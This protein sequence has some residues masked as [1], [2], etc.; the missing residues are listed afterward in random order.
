MGTSRETTAS[1]LEASRLLPV[2]DHDDLT[3]AQ[4]K[5]TACVWC[6]TPISTDTAVDLGQ[7][8]AQ[9]R[10]GHITVSPRACRPCTAERIP[11]ALGQHTATCE[12]CV[13]IPFGCDT[14]TALRQLA[15]EASR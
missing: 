14:A 5:G 15:L 6:R 1:T 12:Q 4:F 2:P 11:A 10:D 3:D 13:D 7:R 9:I 8:R